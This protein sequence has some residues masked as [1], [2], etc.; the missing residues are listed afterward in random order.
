MKQHAAL[1]VVFAAL[2]LMYAHAR[3][4]PTRWG[5]A[6]GD[7]AILTASAV[8][9][10]LLT[11]FWLQAAGVFRS[12]W[13]WTFTYAHAYVSEIPR[14]YAI[15]IFA[16]S[17][18]EVL[19]AAL[20]IWIIAGVGLT[21]LIWSGKARS[22][23]VFLV[24]FT[25]FSF[26]SMCPG[27]FFR[28]QYYVLLLPAV[29]LLVGLAVSSATE[30]LGTR[31]EW[32]S[33][34]IVPVM[35]F[36]IAVLLALSRQSEFLFRATPIRACRMIYGSNPFPEAVELSKYIRE[37]ST[38]GDLLAVLGSEPEFYFYTRLHSAT[39]HIYV[40]GL[41]E[42]QPYASRMQRDMIYEIAKAKPRYIVFTNVYTSWLSNRNGDMTIVNWANAYVHRNYRPVGLVDMISEQQIESYW[43]GQARMATP[44]GSYVYV[45]E[46][47]RG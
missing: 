35:L 2:Y 10:F 15:A 26:L 17:Y 33:L 42:N 9:P 14:R 29:G 12:F 25:A 30:L 38:K 32:R 11:C 13:F 22:Q 16:D 21:T 28:H 43:G 5:L 45:F 34:R 6:F 7:V 44:R 40:Y 27:F 31:R 46:R 41:M 4:K 19:R 3:T 23:W 20:W 24:G 39:G 8:V 37:H 1:F 18:P 47:K 36:A